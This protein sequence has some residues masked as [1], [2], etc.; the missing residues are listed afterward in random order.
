MT[1]NTGFRRVFTTFITLSNQVKNSISELLKES[2]QFNT[3]DVLVHVDVDNRKLLFSPSSFT[4]DLD[5]FPKGILREAEKTKKESGVNSLCIAKGTVQLRIGEKDV[6]TSVLLTP[7]EFAK[8]KIQKTITLLPLEDASFINPFLKHYLSDADLLFQIDDEQLEFSVVWDYLDDQGLTTNDVSII[9][10]FHH[11]RYEIVKELE[12]LLALNELGQNVKSILGEA[13]ENSSDDLNFQADLLF[14]ADVDHEDVFKKASTQNMVIQGPP[15]TGKSQ[16]L[17][18]VLGKVLAGNNTTVVVSEKRVALEVL[19][20]KLSAFGLDKLCFIA[21]SDRLSHSFLQELKSTWDYFESHSAKPI[22]NLR[23]SEQFEANLQMTLDLLAQ[24]KLIGGVSF[25]AFKSIVSDKEISNYSYSSR[26]PSIPHYLDQK[27]TIEDLYSAKLDSVVGRLKIRTIQG[28]DF[29]KLDTKISSWLE[30][31]NVLK[32]DFDFDTWSDFSGLMKEAANCQIYENELYKKYADIFKP[33]SKPQQ[34]FLSLRKKYLKVQSEVEK[35]QSNQSH[36]K[37]VPSNSETISLLESV[38]SAGFF[39]KIQTKKRWRVI[40]NL[41][42]SNA[43]ESLEQHREETSK[44][45][46]LTQIKIKFYEIGVDSPDSE[47]SLIY[48][49]MSVYSEDQWHSLQVIP[50]KKRSRITSHHRSLE[51]LYFELNSNFTLHGETSLFKF[52]NNLNHSFSEILARKEKI[53]LLDELVLETILRNDDFDS[54]KGQLFNSHLTRFKEQFPAFSSFDMNEI[55][56]KVNAIV[57]AQ[58]SEAELF[59]QEIENKVSN[60]FV[61]SHELLS[62]PARKLSDE[63]KELKARLRKGK[64]ILVKEFSKS[65]SHPSLRELFNS[66][67]REWIQLLKPIWL[68]NP[69]QL[70]KCFPLKE[71][72]FDVAIFDEASQIP[73]ANA[74][75]TIQRSNRILVAGDE[76]QMGP[77]SYFKT[78]NSEVVDLLH[79]AN[80]YWSKV[81]LK[82][83]YRSEHPELISFSNTHFYH[84]DLK[85][86]PAFPTSNAIQHH[87]IENG[88]FIDRKNSEEAKSLAK[89]IEDILSKKGTVG[90]VAFSEEQ[91]NCIWSELSASSQQK[92][93]ERL[94]NNQGFFKSLENVQGDECDHLFISF[95]YAKNEDGEFHLRFGP[96]N[97]S[98]GRKRLNVLLTRA[99][100]SIDFFC[101]VR[102]TDFKLSDN[103]SINLLRQWIAFAENHSSSNELDLPFGLKAEVNGNTITFDQI[104]RSLP[105]AREVATLQS[106]MGSRGW[107]VK[108]N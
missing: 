81:E 13:L 35:F 61:K 41:P 82:H 57:S 46:L 70:S 65:R 69:S 55:S 2:S 53:R 72:I 45:D 64:S 98:N 27:S 77:S 43:A 21:S 85:T 31:F 34:R 9:G 50:N 63:Q 5:T 67:A 15:G 37:I 66:E 90:I 56:K 106:V 83:H 71:G 44:T 28:D 18:N 4:F 105:N 26:V 58:L 87:F 89:S 39:T 52:L 100:K 24:D 93:S 38:K 92:L 40:S 49:T 29:S 20:K 97:T 101:S 47:I 62:I 23:L 6:T 102:S 10:N 30:T 33:N 74:L 91:L 3:N 68:S 104:Q 80:Y 7:I 88:K 16:V 95:G 25:H 75:G 78:G 54:F 51:K 1:Q 42:F 73:L 36:W 11:H 84:G 14:P 108:Y 86:F 32:K 8:N 107:E 96:M 59:A 99:I 19:Q 103:E 76:H 12:E 48:Q 79:Q 22:N 60:A 17:S 94:E